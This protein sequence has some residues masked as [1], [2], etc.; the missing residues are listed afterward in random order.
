M[1]YFDASHSTPQS[2]LFNN[3]TKCSISCPYL[4]NSRAVSR[5]IHWHLKRLTVSEGNK[6]S[7]HFVLMLHLYCAYN[8]FTVKWQ[9]HA[10]N[11]FVFLINYLCVGVKKV[12]KRTYC[13]LGEQMSRQLHLHAQKVRFLWVTCTA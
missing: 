3:I 1:C 9:I 4:L 11:I 6:C 13:V 10:F 7:H 2:F 12:G 8:L 5:I